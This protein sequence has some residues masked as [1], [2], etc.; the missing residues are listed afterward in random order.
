MKNTKDTFKSDLG[1]VQV[2]KTYIRRE[3]NDSEHWDRIERT[4]HERELVKKA[5][6]KD[7]Q[8]IEYLPE[9]VYPCIKIKIDGDWN[10]LFFH[11][12]DQ[13]RECYKRLEYNWKAYRQRH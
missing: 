4:F 9:S 10:R 11:I 3:K 6:F 2:S 8:E 13:A 7:I 12:G 5:K 1:E